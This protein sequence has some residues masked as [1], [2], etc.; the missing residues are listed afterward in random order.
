[1]KA[2]EPPS[3]ANQNCTC[4]VGPHRRWSTS[5]DRSLDQ[6]WQIVYTTV[7]SSMRMVTM[8]DGGERQRVAWGLPRRAELRARAG[9][10]CQASVHLR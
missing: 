9:S 8:P 4:V 2:Q 3:I 7:T 1:M 6:V 10:A 5:F